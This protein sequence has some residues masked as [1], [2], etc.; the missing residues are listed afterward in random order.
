MFRGMRR[1]KQAL[2]K[3]ESVAV[4]KRGKSGVLAAAGDDGYPYAVPLSFVYDDGKLFFHCAYEGHKIDA[5][6]RDGKVSFC[7]V[8]KD[9]VK[10][11]E[12]TT[13]FRS[14]IVFGRAK[15]LEDAAEKRA[16]LECLAA[17]YS[18]DH[19]DGRLREIDKLF[20]RTCMV[21]IAIDHMSGKE[22]TE[23]RNN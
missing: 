16:A 18:P 2:T 10:P 12:Y 22:A 15:I 13:Y 14:V 20:D 5:I 17:K 7:V 3:E 23:L 6:K 19:E 11:E 21:Q 1:A 4:L 8:D 9:D